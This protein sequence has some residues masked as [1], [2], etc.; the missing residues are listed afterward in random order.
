MFLIKYKTM[1]REKEDAIINFIS[2]M[3]TD[4]RRTIKKKLKDA[5]IKYACTLGDLF[6]A[7]AELSSLNHEDV[8]IDKPLD[9]LS[10]MSNWGISGARAGE[11]L[12]HYLVVNKIINK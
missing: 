2:D 1:K 10:K 4:D 3:Y 12:R 9:W 7:F 5:E 6:V 8:S 11:M